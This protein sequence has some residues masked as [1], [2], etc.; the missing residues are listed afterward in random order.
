MGYTVYEGYQAKGPLTTAIDNVSDEIYEGIEAMIDVLFEDSPARAQII[1]TMLSAVESDIKDGLTKTIQKYLDQAIRKIDPNLSH[2][3]FGKLEIEKVNTFITNFMEGM[4]ELADE[5]TV[6]ITNTLTVIGELK[7]LDGSTETTPNENQHVT[8]FMG[9]AIQNAFNGTNVI[10]PIIG[11]ICPTC[12][13]TEDNKKKPNFVVELLKKAGEFVKEKLKK[14]TDATV[15]TTVAST[16]T[17]T[18]LNNNKNVKIGVGVS[19]VVLVLIIGIVIYYKRKK[20]KKTKK[21]TAN[22]LNNRKNNKI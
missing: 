2:L 20:A 19:V 18:E 7:H 13:E 15:A 22:S 16:A 21:K 8:D 17:A 10:N 11:A 12:P 9:L 3:E 1:K 14:K 4:N 6:H 5:A